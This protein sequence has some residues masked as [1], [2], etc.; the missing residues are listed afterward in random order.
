MSHF[1]KLKKNPRFSY[2]RD[3]LAIFGNEEGE[4]NSANKFQNVVQWLLKTKSSDEDF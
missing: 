1:L 2:N 3:N 4:K